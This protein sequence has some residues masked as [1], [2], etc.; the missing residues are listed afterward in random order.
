[1][2]V[3]VSPLKIKYFIINYGAPDAV[4]Q[5]SVTPHYTHKKTVGAV[6][7]LLHVLHVSL[8]RYSQQQYI[9]V[10]KAIKNLF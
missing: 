10:R 9:I 3:V 2:L 6:P 8:C 1:M 7:T 4:C 5:L